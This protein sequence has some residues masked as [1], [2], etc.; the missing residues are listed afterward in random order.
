M[1]AAGRGMLAL[2]GLAGLAA[3]EL[4]LPRLAA[5]RVRR[6]L[7]A[8]AEVR[9]RA[10]PALK[11]LAGR[12]D[13]VEIAVDELAT[14][15]GPP[16]G[17]QRAGG[18]R[19][20]DLRAARLRLGPL[21]LHAVHLHKDGDAFGLE[22]RL[23]EAELSAALPSAAIGLRPVA[24]A[25]GGLGLEA[26]ASV[27]GFRARAGGRLEARDGRVVIV[28]EGPL[29]ALG[30]LPVFAR[31]GLRITRVSARALPHGG[32]R[33]VAAGRLEPSAEQPAGAPERPRRA[34]GP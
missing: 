6:E 16:S 4:A 15:G 19:R 3:L 17:L 10:R 12:A 31:R 9:V 13:R 34:V 5:W 26:R 22:A 21:V 30:P 23:S 18:V 32:F 25:G 14:G 20:L 27:F 1:E 24:L 29:A 33:V 11:L 2:Y 8:G 28:G 7:G